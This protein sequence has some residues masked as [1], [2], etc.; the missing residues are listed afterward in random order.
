MSDD[1]RFEDLIQSYVDGTASEADIAE[2]SSRVASDPQAARAFARATRINHFLYQ[3]FGEEEALRVNPL[4]ALKHSGSAS[5]NRKLTRP[6]AKPTSSAVW[7]S[8]S[9]AAAACILLVLWSRNTPPEALAVVRAVDGSVSLQRGQE[10]RPAEV[11][12]EIQANDVL[13]SSSAA[14]ASI[15]FTDKSRVD[16]KKAFSVTIAAGSAAPASRILDLTNGTLTASVTRQAAGTTF[17]V[18]TPHALTTVVGTQFTVAVEEKLT[19]LDVEEGSVDFSPA[20]N[21]AKSIRVKTRQFAIAT[22]GVAPVATSLDSQPAGPVLHVAA[23]APAGGDGSA[24]KPF[25]EIQRAIEAAEPGTAVLVH[26]GVYRESLKTV[27]DGTADKR[28]VIRAE[29]SRRATVT[30]TNG[31]LRVAHAWISVE[32]FVFDGSFGP[33][34]VV[35]VATASNYFQLRNV[36]VANSSLDGIDVDSPQHVM[37]EDCSIH[38]ALSARKDT[39]SHGIVT[40]AVNNFTVRNTEVYYSSGNGISLMPLSSNEPKC[41]DNVTIDG[42]KIWSGSLPEDRNGHKAGVQTGQ[43]GIL[44]TRNLKAPEARLSIRRTEMYGWQDPTQEFGTAVK[45]KEKVRLELAANKFHDNEIAVWTAD[46]T[47]SGSNRP[48]AITFSVANCIFYNNATAI[49]CDQNMDAVQLW[50]NTFGLQN[51]EALQIVAQKKGDYRNNLFVG[52]LVPTMATD[53]SNLRVEATAVEN[54][55]AHNYRSV[56]NS[57]AV[58]AGVPVPV[59]TDAD[60]A[61]RPAGGKVDV[62]A[63]ELKQ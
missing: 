11:G 57:P 34:D 3:H 28:I 29:N 6:R 19:R 63:Y 8:V 37:I 53:R 30:H 36:E 52:T 15:E 46:Y 5:K 49:R 41:W 61:P 18:K 54:A 39:Y 1:G 62:G 58:N 60:G 21:T 31:V 44:A 56:P 13:V 25:Q 26:D 10:S 50:N 23:S 45:V 20:D 2:L 16:L 4:L 42:C 33:S 51:R 9:V 17:A 43:T 32:G 47:V 22:P 59:T 12:T 24:Q 40:Y 7:I 38:H 35:M 27:R 14:S 55:A 48:A